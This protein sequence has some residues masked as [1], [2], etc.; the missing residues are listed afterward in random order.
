MARRWSGAWQWST[1]VSWQT[2]FTVSGLL[3]CL[4][5]S[6][7]LACLCVCLHATC[8]SVA[9]GLALLS[10]ICFRANGSLVICSYM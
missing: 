10:L 5:I 9:D 6:P 8:V 2:S 1:S 3:V 4:S 7:A